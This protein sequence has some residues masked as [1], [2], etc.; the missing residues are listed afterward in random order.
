MRADTLTHAGVR[1]NKLQPK[2]TSLNND[3]SIIRYRAIGATINSS[4]QGQSVTRRFYSPGLNAGDLVASAAGVDI[5]KFYGTGK[6]L[7]G[8][9]ITWEPAVSFNTTGRCFLAFT[10]N[11]EVAVTLQ[12]AWAAWVASPS[13][14]TYAAYADLV[15]AMGS[16]RSWPIW[17]ET[18]FAVPTLLRRKMFD[19]N[20]SITTSPDVYDRSIQV[21]AFMAFE[22]LPPLTT[23]GNFVYHDVV[24]VEGVQPIIT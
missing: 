20:A 3:S 7:P 16:C 11:P 13:G 22:G 23:L 5:C 12:N 9:T 4:T 15:K 21:F 6:F 14:A 10:D 17:Q 1:R 8:T 18:S 19:I 24:Q 2:M